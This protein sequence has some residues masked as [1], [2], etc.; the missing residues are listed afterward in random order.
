MNKT[1]LI[2]A[3]TSWNLYHFRSG[4][5]RDLQAQGYRVIAA[6]PKDAY[7]E[8][9]AAMVSEY[10]AL[11]MAGAGTSLWGDL[12]VWW[13]YLRLLRAV[14]PSVLL[15]YTIKPNIYGALAA[16]L[17]G[18][19]VI[20]NVSGLGTVFIRRNWVTRVATGLY[21]LAF[22][23]RV[24]VLFQN[25]HDRDLFLG[26]KLVNAEKAELLP[27]SGVDL[28]YFSPL[29]ARTED[30]KTAFVL[31]AR[32]L[33][34]K[35][36]S[37]FVDAARLVKA[38]YP[39]VVFRLV[40][41]KDVAN[42]TAIAGEVLAQWVAEGAVEYVGPTEEVR[43]VIAQHDCVVLPSYREG[44]SRVLLEAAAMEKP[45]IAS[46]VP[47]CREVVTEGANG[48][49]CRPRDSKHLADCM[50]RF[51]ELSP[52]QRVQMGQ[53]SRVKVE[54]EFNQQRVFDIYRALVS[55]YCAP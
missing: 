3:N 51:L 41:P 27:G 38:V 33:W 31:I 7:S 5:I 11:P 35:G 15:T 25:T 42:K 50:I 8:R 40:G 16:R 46:D 43:E 20:A 6:A 18:V 17:C 52:P 32:M 36:V 22:R 45:L 54:Q 10:Y 49:L 2:S 39:Q 55:R 19:P 26:M 12:L 14:K 30:G 4:L 29:P 24:T 21:R 44:M 47:G 13:R 48:F 34:D 53:A 9:L 37:E 28:E 23:G 1:L